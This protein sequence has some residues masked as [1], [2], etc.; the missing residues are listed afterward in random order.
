MLPKY[1]SPKWGLSIASEGWEMLTALPKR[2]SRGQPGMANVK[3]TLFWV[4]G[5]IESKKVKL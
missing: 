1:L 4:L 2:G 3:A 5:A